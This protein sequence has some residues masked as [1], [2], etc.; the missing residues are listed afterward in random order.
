M[1]QLKRDTSTAAKLQPS[2]QRRSDAVSFAA[3][4]P[5][6]IETVVIYWL[7][8]EDHTFERGD[9]AEGTLLVSRRNK[10][11]R[12]GVRAVGPVANGPFEVVIYHTADGWAF[13]T[14]CFEEAD[15]E[16]PLRAF[17]A[18]HSVLFVFSGK[19]DLFYFHVEMAG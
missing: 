14:D 8:A 10:S 13:K 17:K 16:Y 6:E 4:Y 5:G 3:L 19:R 18:P 11:I 9:L 1:R 15:A 7:N 2:P 12:F